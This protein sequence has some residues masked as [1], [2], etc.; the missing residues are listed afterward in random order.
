MKRLASLWMLLACAAFSVRGAGVLIEAEA[1]ADHGGWICDTQFTALAEIGS[2]YLM[3]HGLGKAVAPAQTTVE[4]PE[5]GPWRVL[6]RTKD[7]VSPWKA[8]GA[9][10]RFMVVLDGK[11]L[12]VE[13]GTGGEGWHWQDG[14]SVTLKAGKLTVSLQD[15]TG[16]NG[17]CDAILL[18]TDAAL[19]PPNRDPE[20]RV[21]RRALRGT[22]EKPLDGG[23]YDLVVAG[24]GYAGIG[25][26]IAAA[27]QGLSVALIQDRPVLGGNGSSE[28]RVWS[29]GA[30]MH[31]KFPQIGQ[32]TEE[33]ADRAPDSPAA[34]EHFGDAWKEQIIRAEPK[35]KLFLNHYVMSAE[36]DEKSRA[37][38]SIV[39]LDCRSGNERKFS[40]KLFADCTGHGHLG[41]FAGAAYQMT[42]TGRMGTSN[43]WIW[44]QADARQPWPETPW[45][46][47]IEAKKDFPGQPLSQSLLEGAK[48]RKGEWY[49]ESGYDKHPIDDL[50]RI[51][52]WNLRAVFGAF[53]SIRRQ[54]ENEKAALRWVSPVGGTRE[55]RRLEGDV[56]L[57]KPD[58]E[59]GR[60]FPDG[61]VTTTFGLDLHYPKE[62]YRGAA[63]E[64]PYISRADV[65]PLP[66]RQK[67]YTIPYRCLYSRNVPN[68]FMAGRN[69]SVTHEALGTV[70]V[71][72]NCG[73]MG[74]VV[75]KAAFVAIKN[76]TNP[77]GVYE[78]Y[79]DEL[80]ELLRQP[81][82]MRR[83]QVNEELKADETI[84]PQREQHERTHPAIRRT[85]TNHKDE[86]IAP[87]TLEGIVIDDRAA[88]VEGYWWAS[89]NLPG[90]IGDCYL[91]A[92]GGTNARIRYE[93]TVPKTGK[94]EVRISYL[95]FENRAAGV[96]V[97][98]E[99]A[100]EGVQRL[101]V[102]MRK[103][104]ELENHFH[105]L[106]TW[107]FEVE[108]KAALTLSA[109]E[110]DGLVHA[111]CVQVLGK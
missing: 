73:M 12:P 39:A 59:A 70:R 63:P 19:K 29:D 51:R 97:V 31:G 58:I 23:N 3:A 71:M 2:P 27:R 99:G 40:G 55:S 62:Q 78:K 20:L 61:C 46:L 74:E 110:A 18:T 84:A 42:E 106:G 26:A 8:P 81:H 104:P 87:S 11:A 80:A 33:F 25:A 107:T 57:S 60:E 75:G 43:L 4:I 64:N 44:Q 10:G 82:L 88:I 103:K 89:E 28:V 37:I 76:E 91:R 83:T 15:L 68:L 24:G 102:N 109:R 96:P 108:K 32:M 13:F 50:E 9:P 1:F 6:V 67:G 35:I 111:D 85:A 90:Y 79:W 100:T 66:D 72:R 36:C 14:G 45:A 21:F 95:P 7:W 5:T 16:F 94:Y 101:T 49:W 65:R 93:F 53:S 56:I 17:R 41:T 38:Q 54:P 105:R 34:A 30:T 52:D 77:R 69:I 86:H 48:F 47:Q 22:A 92:W 98:I